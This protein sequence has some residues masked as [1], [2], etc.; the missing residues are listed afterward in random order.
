MSDEHIEQVERA[1]EENDDVEGHGMEPRPVDAPAAA[2][3]EPPDVEG[4]SMEPRPV[5]ALA[6]TEE[7][8]DVEGHQ[9]GGQVDPRPID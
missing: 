9:L 1:E 5:D 7:P 3:E 2:T 8:P 4:H 6:A